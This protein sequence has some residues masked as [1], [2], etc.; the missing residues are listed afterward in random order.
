MLNRELTYS[1]KLCALELRQHFVVVL[2]M[3]SVSVILYRLL[4][5][6][7]HRLWIILY[8]KSPLH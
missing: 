7:L 5:V 4:K 8:F 1:Y 2:N 6:G 3:R